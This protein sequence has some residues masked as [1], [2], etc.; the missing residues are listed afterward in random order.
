MKGGWSATMWGGAE[1]EGHTNSALST[2]PAW[3]LHPMI[4][5]S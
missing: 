2:E 3:V 1:R 5:G 4:P